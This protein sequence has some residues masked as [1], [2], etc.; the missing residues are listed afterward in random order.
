MAQDL[1]P[2]RGSRSPDA[3]L[4]HRY[5]GRPST[6]GHGLHAERIFMTTVRVS[7]P[8]KCPRADLDAFCALVLM[9]GEVMAA[10]LADRVRQAAFLAFA[11]EDETLVGVAAL[12]NPHAGYRADVF[13]KAQGGA[14]ANFPYELGWAYVVP[15]AR[16]KRVSTSLVEALC[17]R[18]KAGVY[19]PSRAANKAMHRTLRRAGVEFWCALRLVRAFRRG[20]TSLPTP[21]D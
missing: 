17:A 5:A 15:A 2:A 11:H 13:T 21:N 1:P 9:G 20:D 10:G 19:A 8:A 16:G 14:A 12:K 7:A 4:Y 18:G 6:G 3:G